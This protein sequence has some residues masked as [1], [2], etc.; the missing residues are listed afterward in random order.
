MRMN[1]VL[2][3]RPILLACFVALI[4]A[5]DGG[6]SN[7]TLGT[8]STVGGAGGAVGTGG[9]SAEHCVP[10]ATQDCVGAG[11]CSGAQVCLDDGS[12]WGPCDCGSVGAGGTGGT[13][14]TDFGGQ[15]ST[16]SGG[17]SN[18]G[19][20]ASDGQG[21]SSLS[22]G[23]TNSTSVVATTTGGAVASGGALSTTIGGSATGGAGTTA[24]GGSA[25][26]GAATTAIGGSATGGAAA[27]AG[28]G[29]PA[30]G[31]SGTTTGGS[32][33]GGAKTCPDPLLIDDFEDGDTTPCA[34]SNWV[35]AWWMVD[36]GTGTKTPTT[37]AELPAARTVTR[38]GSLKGLHVQG[39]GFSVWGLAIGMTFNNPDNTVPHIVDLS[40]HTGVTFWLRGSGYVRFQLA[41]S[42]TQTVANG[43]TCIVGCDVNFETSPIS[44]GSTWIRQQV[45]FSSLYNSQFSR[46]A[47]TSDLKRAMTFMFVTATSTFDVWID[48]IAFY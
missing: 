17:S 45:I 10:G 28:G 37:N 23:G 3:L 12:Q 32:S 25:T 15:T 7:R 35:S 20:S 29:S 8:S 13:G 16:G 1:K 31:T 36:D 44:L 40:T 18:G 38:A 24:I 14:T 33:A 39:S 11:R 30:G 47:S 43:G 41:T 2:E 46:D 27:T 34:M 22:L 26:G 5:C 42:D 21:G 48:D 9:A 19:A 6:N 4:S